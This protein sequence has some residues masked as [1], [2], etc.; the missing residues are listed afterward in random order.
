[1]EVPKATATD[2]QPS[3]QVNQIPNWM[4]SLKNQ[5]RS[6][7]SVKPPERTLQGQNSKEAGSSQVIWWRVSAAGLSH[8]TSFSFSNARR[9]ARMT[10]R[11]LSPPGCAFMASRNP[12]YLGRSASRSP[13]SIRYIADA[14]P[15]P[16]P[17]SGCSSSSS[18]PP[19]A[20]ALR[21][22][23]MRSRTRARGTS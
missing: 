22:C 6:E 8:V 11:S 5:S 18:S 21:Y 12:A 13:R 10:A 4:H 19:A 17:A 20:A 23:R 14:E 15:P 2:A 9:S 7:S 1:M 3:L 16:P